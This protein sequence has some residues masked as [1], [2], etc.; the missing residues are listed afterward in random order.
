MGL[1]QFNAHVAEASAQNF[2]GVS[3]VKRGES[4]GEFAFTYTN[5]GLASPL[6]IQVLNPSKSALTKNESTAVHL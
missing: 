4:D 3:N 6:G 5:N 1:R 2:D